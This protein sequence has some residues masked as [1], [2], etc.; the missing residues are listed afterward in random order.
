[1]T[2]HERMRKDR[3]KECIRPENSANLSVKAAI[4]AS[5]TPREVKGFYGFDALLV[6]SFPISKLWMNVGRSPCVVFKR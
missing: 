3:T 5:W 6:V 4:I 1:M 2:Q